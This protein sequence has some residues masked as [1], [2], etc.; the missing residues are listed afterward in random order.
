MSM[1]ESGSDLCFFLGCDQPRG[2]CKEENAEER[3]EEGEQ[4]E[5]RTIVPVSVSTI[6]SQPIY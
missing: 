6:S 1:L 2:V 3:V 4:E 5:K